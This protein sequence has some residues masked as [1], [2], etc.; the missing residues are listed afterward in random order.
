MF[1]LPVPQPTAQPWK[2]LLYV[3]A[4]VKN[5]EKLLAVVLAAL[6]IWGVVGKVDSAI[7]AHDSRVLAADKAA[8]QAQADKNAVL[9][10]A[11]AAM[12]AQATAQ[13]AA[14]AAA[15][16]QLEASNAALVSALAK[17]KATDAQLPPAELAARIETLASLPPASVVPAQNGYA[18]TAPAAVAIA[19]HLEIVPVLQAQ[20]ANTIVEKTNDEKVIADDKKLVDGL[21]QQITGLGLQ[22]GDQ[23]KQCKAQVADEIA[24]ARKSKLKWFKAGVVVGFVAGVVTMH[25][26]P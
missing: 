5:H 24:K 2:A 1:D 9:A 10:Q 19:Q 3:S 22:I 4:F 15:N 8:T 23:T 20:L 26:I 7:S 13:A 14:T 18:V 6:L 21:N 12:A 17:Q 11:N 25:Y 16:Q